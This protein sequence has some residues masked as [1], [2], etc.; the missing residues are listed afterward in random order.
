MFSAG[1][2]RTHQHASENMRRTMVLSVECVMLLL[3]THGDGT[4]IW[5][6]R[7]WEEISEVNE[8]YSQL[9]LIEQLMRVTFLLK[10]NQFIER[11]LLACIVS[12][13][14]LLYLKHFCRKETCSETVKKV[15][16]YFCMEMIIF[17]YKSSE[18]FM[19]RERYLRWVRCQNKIWA[20]CAA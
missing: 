18:F 5:L 20:R 15:L 11:I 12:E 16:C 4:K 19:S 3:N 14:I 9:C 2:M 8:S 6:V 17:L 1:S 10:E 7:I 13:T